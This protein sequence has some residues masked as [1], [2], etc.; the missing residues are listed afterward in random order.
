MTGD[1][2]HM[3][4]DDNHVTSSHTSVDGTHV[5]SS[6]VTTGDCF[7]TTAERSRVSTGNTTRCECHMTR[8]LLILMKYA[9]KHFN[10]I[11]TAPPH[12][13]T[14]SH[15]DATPTCDLTT[16]TLATPALD[17]NNVKFLVDLFHECS[18]TLLDTGAA[19]LKAAHA[20]SVAE[21]RG[22]CDDKEEGGARKEGGGVGRADSMFHPLDFTEV[23]VDEPVPSL[24]LV[25]ISD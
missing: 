18:H 7:T 11:T 21:Q 20:S 1:G 5:A 19:A 3:T 12:L 24:R 25:N 15:V 2:D 13:D 14:S 4:T 6:N 10:P 9:L 17:A 8:E 16:P 23:S 22:S